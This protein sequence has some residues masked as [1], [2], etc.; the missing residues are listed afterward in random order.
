MITVHI[1]CINILFARGLKSVV[2][3]DENI[4]FVGTSFTTDELFAN[5]KKT[6]PDVLIYDTN[7][8]SDIHRTVEQIKSISPKTKFVAIS[9]TENVFVVRSVINSGVNSYLFNCC[10]EEE[11]LNAVKASSK[12]EKFFCGKVL[13]LMLEDRGIYGSCD[14]VSLS[15][16]EV[17]ILKMIAESNSTKD[18]SKKLFLS[19]HTVNTHRKNI[20]KK[21]GLRNP[22]DLVKFAI[23]NG[24]INS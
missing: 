24:L 23:K 11:V 9:D 22:A 16:R 19:V 13:D 17:E 2:K 18:I 10:D 3:S 6:Q 4:S 7:I 5:L 12:N 20:I 21:I 8:A 1:A 15:T 14:P